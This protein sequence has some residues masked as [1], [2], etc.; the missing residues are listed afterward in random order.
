M[1]SG[2]GEALAV[3]TGTGFT[4]VAGIARGYGHT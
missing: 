2:L 3:E 1:R 4:R